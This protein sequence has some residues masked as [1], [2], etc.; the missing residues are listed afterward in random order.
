VYR[1]WL[2][3]ARE[4]AVVRWDML[5]VG[6]SGKEE[7][8][9]STVVEQLKQSPKGIWYATR[10]R[11]KAVPP[12]ENDEVVDIYVDF[13]VDLMDSLFEPPKVGDVMK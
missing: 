1:F 8:Q 2:D 9:S 13:D 11:V 3:P 6:D 7:V 5:V 4:F 12:V 10:F